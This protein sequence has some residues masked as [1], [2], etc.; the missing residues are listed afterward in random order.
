M[1]ITDFR[2]YDPAVDAAA[3]VPD[4]C[5]NYI[6]VLKK[7][8]SLPQTAIKPVMKTMKGLQVIY[9]GIASKSLR[10]RDVKTH[11]D[12]N[13]GR[14]TLRKSL[15]CVFGYKFVPRDANNPDNGKVK[16]SDADEKRLSA[17]MKKN[18]ILYY[19][20]NDDFA[21]HELEL[22]NQF[23]PPF[24]L[25]DNHNEVNSL[26][27]SSLS[28]MRSAKRNPVVVPAP[29]PKKKS[30]PKKTKKQPDYY[31]ELQKYAYVTPQ[32]PFQEPEPSWFEK[33]SNTQKMLLIIAAVGLFWWFFAWCLDESSSSTHYN[34]VHYP[35][36]YNHSSSTSTQT[37]RS[38]K[39]YD[40]SDPKGNRIIDEMS[41][42]D[43]KDYYDYH[44]GPEGNLGSVDYHDIEDYFG[45]EDD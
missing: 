24:N 1:K 9:T 17:W 42:G 16:F 39:Q 31:A 41:K 22:I 6:I 38:T 19:C 14:S 43:Y 44:D 29:A 37:V 18:L 35:S 5:G 40:F 32:Q 21:A 25:K 3:S 36:S 2:P 7:G 4:A 15:G 28:D 33:L 20:V 45:G 23:N 26:F 10:T 12:G 13:A 30:A 34:D 27:R 11:F 8:C